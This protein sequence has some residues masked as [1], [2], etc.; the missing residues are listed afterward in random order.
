CPHLFF[1]ASILDLDSAEEVELGMNVAQRGSLLHRILER[2][3]KEADEPNDLTSLLDRLAPISREEFDNAPK[4]DGFRP[5]PLWETEQKELFERLEKTIEAIHKVSSGWIPAHHEAAFG[6]GDAEKLGIDIDGEVVY[7][8][9]FIDRVDENKDGELRIIDYKTGSTLLGNKDLESGKRLQ[10]P[11]YAMAARD[12]LKLGDP[13]EGFYWGINQ[14]KAGS[15][16]LSKYGVEA[17]MDVVK[18]FIRKALDG[19]HKGEFPPVPPDSGCPEYCPAAAW[20]FHYSP[21]IKFS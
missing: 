16:K 19:I 7:L 13:V 9:G 4:T 3:F 8:R 20:C 6:F 12:A 1:V 5:T 14:A 11:L 18:G 21:G 17:S 10:L 15:L 2:V